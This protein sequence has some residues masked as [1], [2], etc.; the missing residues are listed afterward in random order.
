[1]PGA[2]LAS[3]KRVP[4]PLAASD[5]PTAPASPGSEAAKDTTAAG[6]KRFLPFSTGPRQ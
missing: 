1:M 4:I 6:P 3:S 2:E 5:A